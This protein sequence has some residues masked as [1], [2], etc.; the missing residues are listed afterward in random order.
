M[1]LYCPNCGFENKHKFSR[2]LFNFKPIYCPKCEKA[3]FKKSRL[4]SI[5][6][7]VV[8]LVF[9]FIFDEILYFSS[10][11]KDYSFRKIIIFFIAVLFGII[12]E[13]VSYLILLFRYRKKL[14]SST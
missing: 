12:I 13:Y 2:Y 8:I 6:Q 7:M 10:F 14:V 9:L 1:K 11:L 4:L 5:L 3:F